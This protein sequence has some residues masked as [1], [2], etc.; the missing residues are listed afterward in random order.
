ML[1]KFRE[2]PLAPGYPDNQRTLYSPVDDVHGALLYLLKSAQHSLVVAM[3]GFAD[4]EL[5]D[6]LRSKL[7]DSECFVQ[8]TLDSTQAGGVSE[9]KL[10]AEE[11]YPASS[12]AIGRSERGAIMHLKAVVIDGI[13]TVTGST[14][15]SDSGES[16]QSN[17][18]VVIADPYV[19]AET[20]ARIDQTHANMLAKKR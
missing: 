10:L 11:D 19:A 4:D 2:K 16:K 5:A 9:R 13:W 15:W 18:L 7:I 20:R 8:L 1:D 14:N 6:V 12:L 3:Y 17:A